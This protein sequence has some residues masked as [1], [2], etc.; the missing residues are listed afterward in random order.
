MTNAQTL[1]LILVLVAVS[2]AIGIAA[3]FRSRR[4]TSRREAL[5]QRLRNITLYDQAMANRL[6]EFERTELRRKG[7]PDE[8][9]EDLMQRAIDR[10]ERDNASAA[11]LY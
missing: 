2:V 8:A 4:K 6:I 5:R 10:W 1:T 11:P 7:R 3:F 9:L